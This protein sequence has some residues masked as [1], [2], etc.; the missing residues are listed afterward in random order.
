MDIGQTNPGDESNLASARVNK[1]KCRQ[2]SLPFLPLPV[3][4]KPLWAGTSRPAQ[5]IV[6]IP[7]SV[8][9]TVV[10]QHAVVKEYMNEVE[11]TLLSTVKT[12]PWRF[13]GV[14]QS[15]CY[16]QFS[17]RC[18]G[19]AVSQPSQIPENSPIPSLYRRGDQSTEKARH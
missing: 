17:G 5:R 3:G 8:P 13:L 19:R 2:C 4:G 12:Q 14:T 9:V 11:E 6:L 15:D 7:S 1:Q 18:K 10:I 16:G